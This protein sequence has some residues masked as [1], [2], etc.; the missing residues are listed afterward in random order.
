LSGRV[1]GFVEAEIAD[2]VF[3]RVTRWILE[4]PLEILTPAR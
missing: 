3:D 4:L 1:H 2:V